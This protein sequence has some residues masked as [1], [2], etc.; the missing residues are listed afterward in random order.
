M[1]DNGPYT[2]PPQ[3]PGGEG[4]NSG[5][6]PPYGGYGD[7]NAA[8]QYPGGYNPASGG[9][10]GFGPQG[11]YGA[12]PQPGPGFQ[13]PHDQQMFQG[14]GGGGQPPYPGGTPGY[15]PP[16]KSS[17]GLWIVIGG[18]AVILVLVV[19][20]VVMLLRTGG[21]TPTTPTSPEETAPQADP[22][23]EQPEGGE[24]APKGEA[25]YALPEDACKVLTETQASEY[26][27]SDA[28]SKNLSDS[29]SSCNWS[30][31]GE[32][33]S[34]GT[35]SVEY[36]T[37]YAGSDSIEGAKTDYKDAVESAT[38]TDNSYTKIKI[39]N[40]EEVDL[41]NEATL[42]FSEQKGVSTQS[43]AELLVRQDNININIRYTMSGN[44]LEENPPAPLKYS[45]VEEL[46][47]EIGKLAVDHVGA[48]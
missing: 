44:V 20:V 11:P 6:Q 37:P 29:R 5:G 8:A 47:P 41:G 32:D 19:A 9:Q 16:K 3:Y 22:S 35:L 4:N 17:A 25:P 36:Q 12:G 21:G 43:V 13:Q 34:Y 14:G 40:E 10:P 18:G 46:V 33:R 38:D 7:P 45:D 42:V 48:S 39:L 27:S 2:Q 30:L 26:G 28:G 23:A 15:P 1:S 31:S 24:G